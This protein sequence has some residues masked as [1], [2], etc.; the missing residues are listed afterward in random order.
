MKTFRTALLVGLCLLMLGEVAYAG[1]VER[2]FRGQVIITNRQAPARFRS[3]GAFVHWLRKNRI[4][5]V[6]A[7][8]NKQRVAKKWIFEFM[9]FFKHKLNDIEVKVRFYDVTEGRKFI[10]ADNFFTPRR[11]EKILASR[12]VLEVP[13][14][15]VNRKYQMQVVGP[16]NMLLSSTNFWLRGKKQTYSGRV[17]FSDEEARKR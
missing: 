10:A 13:R 12:M 8:K 5:S 6:W 4:K 7:L 9:A 16:R 2:V 17:T 15:A 1:A 3:Q 11:G 14:F